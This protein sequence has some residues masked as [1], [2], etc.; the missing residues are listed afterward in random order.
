[1]NRVA[2]LKQISEYMVKKGKF[3][4]MNEYKAETDA[5]ANFYMVRKLWGSWARLKQLMRSNHPDLWA[6]MEA[7]TGLAAEPVVE[8]KAAK[9]AKKKAVKKEEK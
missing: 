2:I 4:S 5:P 3:L 8:T 9:P 7:G 1:M 6:Q